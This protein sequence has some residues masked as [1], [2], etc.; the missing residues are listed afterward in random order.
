MPALAPAGAA[1]GV[2]PTRV[3]GRD[4]GHAPVALCPA[5]VL[6]APAA[7]PACPRRP[8]AIDAARGGPGSERRLCPGAATHLTG[9]TRSTWLRQEVSPGDGGR[10]ARGDLELGTFRF[11]KDPSRPRCCKG[12]SLSCT[13]GTWAVRRGRRLAVYWGPGRAWSVLLRGSGFRIFPESQ[14]AERFGLRAP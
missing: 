5:I 3:R 13:S 9:A 8:P 1:S 7:A 2:S 12:H 11:S 4:E 10:G 6:P 14:P